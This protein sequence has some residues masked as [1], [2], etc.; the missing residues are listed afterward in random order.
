M[1]SLLSNHSFWLFVIC[2]II[3]V[4][5]FLKTDVY[6]KRTM[7]EHVIIHRQSKRLDKAIKLAM[8][9]KQPTLIDV[10]NSLKQSGFDVIIHRIL[11]E[12]IALKLD[13]HHVANQLSVVSKLHWVEIQD[14]VRLVTKHGYHDYHETEN[15]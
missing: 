15:L 10:V 1:F 3:T 5:T 11:R 8:L 14:G 2:I 7:I 13:F 9:D 6:I 12:A 4:V